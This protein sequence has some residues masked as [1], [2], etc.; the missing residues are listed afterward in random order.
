MKQKN[1]S[2]ECGAKKLLCVLLVLNMIVCFL[3][4]LFFWLLL[5]SGGF[6]F[7]VGVGFWRLLG[8]VSM[9]GVFGSVCRLLGVVL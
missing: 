6:G 8:R 9:F 4:G 3:K 5:K 7:W 2:W 1:V